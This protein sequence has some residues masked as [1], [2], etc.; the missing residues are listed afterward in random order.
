LGSDLAGFKSEITKIVIG[1]I[2]A[3]DN[4]R[5]QFTFGVAV[6]GSSGVGKSKPSP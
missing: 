2:E 5:G 4:G 3:E 6:M 1:G